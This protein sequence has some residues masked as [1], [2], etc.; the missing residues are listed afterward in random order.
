MVPLR[1]RAA[2]YAM[3]ERD[4]LLP[5]RLRGLPG[6]CPRGQFVKETRVNNT[7]AVRAGS[8]VLALLLIVG[9]R[10]A[11]DAGKGSTPASASP[12]QEL[13]TT[14][15]SGDGDPSTMD[16]PGNPRARWDDPPTCFTGQGQ[17]HFDGYGTPRAVIGYYTHV[18]QYSKRV[19]YNG[20]GETRYY[21][22]YTVEIWNIYTGMTLVGWAEKHCGTVVDHPGWRNLA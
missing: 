22:L 12:V 20:H 9:G 1:G 3:E 2:D 14:T 19:T 13:T 4:D 8:A 10:F 11:I 17:W 6:P 21:W 15:T 18:G 16:A 5:S 7:V